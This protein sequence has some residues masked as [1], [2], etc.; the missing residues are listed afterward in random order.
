MSDEAPPAG[1]YPN[2]DGSR[3]LRWWS[4]V[5]WTEYTREAGTAPT[6]SEQPTQ[7]HA[8]PTA[9]AGESAAPTEVLGEASEQPA[10]AGEATTPTEVL[11]E[12]SEQPAPAAAPA[13]PAQDQSTAP[14]GEQQ[15]AA[16]SDQTQWANPWG[17][18]VA[19]PPSAP[20]G[21]YA[22]YAPPAPTPLTQSGMRPLSDMFSDIG[23]IVRRAWLPILG[24]SFII[25]AVLFAL[26]AA[27]V[28][29]AINVP[30][31]RSG[32]DALA[33][34]VQNNPD[35]TI[36]SAA[37]EKILQ[38]FGDA[39]SRLAPGAWALLG[40]VL[41]LLLM[42]GS[43]VQIAAVSRLS[44]DA[45][46]GRPVS[47]GAGLR[48]GFTGGMRLLGY[49]IL[50][51]IIALLILTA[52]IL[53]IAVA[54]QV[55][56]ALAGLL[57]FAAVIATIFVAIWLTGRFVPVAP[58]AVVSRH[59]LRWSWQHTRGKFWAVLGRYLLWSIAASIIIQV[60]TT[61]IAIP[62]SLIFLGQLGSSSSADQ[63]GASL[64]LQLL[65][66]PFTM[67]LGAITVLGITPIWRD[68]SDDPD[69][70]SIDEHGVPVPPPE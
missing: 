49:W 43:F 11:G 59:A 3:G 62:M 50:V 44:M 69:Y 31:L 19:Q 28:A 42:I 17:Q 29:S 41:F 8:E 64:E 66:L 68:L 7:P 56:P 33:T 53:V 48:S 63:L 13:E 70:R 65:L 20:I 51:G 38:D 10:P 21:G 58:Q 35:G 27:I 37:G 9:V 55:S 30:A 61:I 26:I 1:W 46:A 22:P 2:P 45:A 25:W 32:L 67:A 12:A 16:L 34:E 54:A 60:I 47:W 23:R 52:V 5:G 18:P 14:T 6:V 40:G 57:A 39:F 15:T 36:S 4:G 24:I